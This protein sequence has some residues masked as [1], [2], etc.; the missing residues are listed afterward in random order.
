M[1]KKIVNFGKHLNFYLQITHNSEKIK[2]KKKRFF[3]GA[4]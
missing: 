2:N 3:E 4:E 1:L